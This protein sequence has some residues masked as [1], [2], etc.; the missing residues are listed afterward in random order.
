MIALGSSF[1]KS[2]EYAQPMKL[3][4][5]QLKLLKFYER[6]RTVPLTFTGVMRSYWIP[7]V[8]ILVLAGISSWFIWAGWPAL[9]W[10]YIG[11]CLGAIWRD[12]NHI[13][14]FLRTWPAQ[15]EVIKWERVNDLLTSDGK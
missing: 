15:H 5:H 10:L 3:T 6:H 12:V 14:V 4:K 9:G 7:W 1:Y 13:L 8:L 11:A 2:V